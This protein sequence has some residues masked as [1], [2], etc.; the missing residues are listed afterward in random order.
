[1]REI[2]ISD[3]LEIFRTHVVSENSQHLGQMKLS[4]NEIISSL[5][6]NL[7]NTIEKIQDDT[8]TINIETLD[9]IKVDL[10]KLSDHLIDSVEELEVTV[11]K[12]LDVFLLLVLILYDI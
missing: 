12:K 3:K 4:F 11:Q 9:T 8:K 10:Q 7:R 1:M 6:E 5:Q 2:A